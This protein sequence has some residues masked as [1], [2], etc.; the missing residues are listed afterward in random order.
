M[1]S[2]VRPICRARRLL[3]RSRIIRVTTQATSGAITTVASAPSFASSRRSPVNA[4]LETRMET[5]K[6]IPAHTPAAISTG[7]LI[8]ARGPWRAGRVASQEPVKMPIG[9]P[10]R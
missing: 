3:G 8:R 10:T 5:V 1:S 7:P 6:P 4:M 9:L 2:A